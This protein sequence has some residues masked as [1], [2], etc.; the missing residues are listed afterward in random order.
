MNDVPERQIDPL[1]DDLRG[2]RNFVF[3]ELLNQGIEGATSHTNQI[4]TIRIPTTMRLQ[5]G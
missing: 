1:A 5:A 3:P 4:P 2:F